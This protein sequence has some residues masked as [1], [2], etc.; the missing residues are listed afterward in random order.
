MSSSKNLLVFASGKGTL[1]QYLYLNLAELGFQKIAL[2]TSEIQS[3]VARFAAEKNIQI[4]DAGVDDEVN[5]LNSMASVS[6]C[7]IV[8]AG[9]TKKIPDI[10]IN[11]FPEKIINTHPSLLPKFGGKGMYGMRVHKSVLEAG[12]SESGCT[13]HFVTSEYDSGQTI[14]Q[15]KVK[16][17]DNETPA[18]L[19]E[20]VKQAE[21]ENLRIA[22]LKLGKK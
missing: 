18:S 14:S 8:L 21:K 16:I 19:Q 22:I 4:L 9:F 5:L 17:G 20:K 3:P 12:E 10:I 15:K 2:A 1:F 11:K 6:P 7:L 13:V